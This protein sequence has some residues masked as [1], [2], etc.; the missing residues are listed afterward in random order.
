[1]I[2]CVRAVVGA[3]PWKG[4]ERSPYCQTGIVVRASS[5]ERAREMALIQGGDEGQQAWLDPANSYVSIVEPDGD[6]EVILTDL[7]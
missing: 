4:K 6:D 5:P 1:V 7:T 3:P 2:Y